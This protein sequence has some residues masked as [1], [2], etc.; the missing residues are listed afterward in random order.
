MPLTQAR[1]LSD[2]INTPM[3]IIVYKNTSIIYVAKDLLL[4]IVI[5]NEAVAQNFREYFEF[6]WNISKKIS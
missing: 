6:I 5:E 3:W 4:G 1:Y 2:K